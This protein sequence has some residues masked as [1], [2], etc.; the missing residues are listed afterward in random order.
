MY[1]LPL[2]GRWCLPF[3]GLYRPSNFWRLV[4]RLFVFVSCTKRSSDFTFCVS[5]P[6]TECLPRGKPCNT[7][8]TWYNKWYPVCCN[9]EARRPLAYDTKRNKQNNVITGNPFRMVTYENETD[10]TEDLFTSTAFQGT[11]K[12]KQTRQVNSSIMCLLRCLPFTKFCWV[13]KI[14]ITIS[15]KSTN[16]PTQGQ[17]NPRKTTFK[18]AFGPLLPTA[19]IFSWV[20]IDFI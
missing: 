2:A 7:I 8:P 4:R 14:Y 9:E 3:C 13:G 10:L 15:M 12:A 6:T 20:G 19:N 1:R 5:H 11:W 17:P 16:S 18:A